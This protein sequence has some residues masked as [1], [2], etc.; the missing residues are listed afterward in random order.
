MTVAALDWLGREDVWSGPAGI[1]TRLIEHLWY[2][3]LALAVAAAIALPLGF[4]VGHT[5]RG[6]TSVGALANVWRALPTLGLVILIFRLEPLS[7]WPVLFALVVVAVPPMLLNA[8]AGIRA[9]DPEVRD[10]ARGMGLSGRQTLWQIEIPLAMPLILTGVRSAAGQ[11]IATATVAAFVGLG[12]LGRFIIDGYAARDIGEVTGG[13][14]VVA[15][16]ALVVDG[17]FVLAQRALVPARMPR[18]PVTTPAVRPRE[19]HP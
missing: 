18:S 7:I 15:S 5:G 17:A 1:P 8:D 4:V 9:I 2:S 3:G 14:I 6:G 12:G 11:V 16:L 10:A 19:A 13:A